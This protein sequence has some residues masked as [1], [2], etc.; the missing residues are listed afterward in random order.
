MPVILDMVFP[1]SHVRL[2]ISAISGVQT[3]LEYSIS[4]G[5]VRKATLVISTESF[6]IRNQL[7]GYRRAEKAEREP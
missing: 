4:H 3:S 1:M 6:N 5:P 7:S 2:R